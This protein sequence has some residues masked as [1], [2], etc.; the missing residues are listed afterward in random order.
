MTE[1]AKK[2]PKGFDLQS[3]MDNT[4]NGERLEF[5]IDLMGNATEGHYKSRKHLEPTGNGFK[6]RITNTEGRL[7]LRNLDYGYLKQIELKDEHGNVYST[8]EQNAQGHDF[9]EQPYK[10]AED[11]IKDATAW[12]KV[13]EKERTKR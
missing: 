8:V 11:V 1:P 3:A 6:F 10:N 7:S 2:E 4:V 9:D 12:L 5:R 13:R